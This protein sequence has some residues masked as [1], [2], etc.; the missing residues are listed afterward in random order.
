MYKF[1]IMSRIKYLYIALYFG[2]GMGKLAANE[3]FS[4]DE[5]VVSL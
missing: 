2:T 5:T 4:Y 3:L 1:R